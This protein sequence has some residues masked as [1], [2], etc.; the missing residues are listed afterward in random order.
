MENNDINE[1]VIVEQLPKI[2]QQ[3]Q[4]ISSEIDK[5]IA[6]ALSLE[7]TEDSKNEV[8]KAKARLN[9]I[10]TALEEKR[11]EVKRAILSPYEE[12]EG[13]YTNL[14]KT[15]L[16]EA[17]NEL[18]NKI[19]SI[20]E[21]QKYEK[22]L[23][24]KDFAI[25]YIQKYNLEDYIT[26]EDMNINITLSASMKSLQEQVIS[27]CERIANDFKLINTL[28]NRN[29][30]FLEYTQNG[31]K[32]NEA[33]LLVKE[34]HRKIEEIEENN[35]KIEEKIESEKV[36]EAKIEE[37]IAPKEIIEDEETITIQFKVT[38]T[39]TK[40]KELKQFLIDGGY[41]YD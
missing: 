19:T 30:I 27:Y 28:E 12:F 36:T 14:I 29:E 24:L 32:L 33:M 17:D 26:F 16:N 5:E 37:I 9:K 31:F 8:K 41:N 38:A 22:M 20:E 15:K 39:K 1:L 18:K 7:C 10:G 35:K 23:D 6:L 3:L 11:K 4:L 21:Q 40:L 34:R 13:I 2:T 25:E